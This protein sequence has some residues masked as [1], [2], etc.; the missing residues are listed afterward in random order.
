MGKREINQ[1]QLWSMS[2]VCCGTNFK[3][4]QYMESMFPDLELKTAGK[5]RHVG[6]ELED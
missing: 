3:V 6:R 1:V 4:V 5:N 2:E